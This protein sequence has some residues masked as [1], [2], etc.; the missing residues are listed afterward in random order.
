MTSRKVPRRAVLGVDAAWTVTEPSG[1]A[2]GVETETG[3]RLEAV[4]ASYDDF[5]AR[6]EGVE[7]GCE[8]PRG[9]KPNAAALLA[10][11]QKLGRARV[12]LVAV[13]MPLSWT[14][15]ERRRA[16]DDEVSRRYGARKAA[17]HSPSR[18]RPGRISDD[19][20][21]E[22]DQEGYRLCVR[23]PARG[24]IEVYP[25]AAL[26][27]FLNARERLKYKAAKVRAYWPRLSEAERRL[28][29]RNAWAQ[30][31]AALDA[32]LAGVAAALPPP[33][34]DL[35]A[36]RLKAYEDKLDAVVCAAVAIACLDGKAVAHG[37]EAAAIWV[38]SADCPHPRP[39]PAS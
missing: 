32:R 1:V 17:V 18:E 8:R 15:I 4:E 5:L 25:H 33:E 39:L 31:V 27:E 11:A 3:W 20:R 38:P 29:L 10:A 13:D 26:I 2:L 28:E 14:A 22:L 23:P 19:L 34:G 16:C 21:A 36:W 24:L 9:S 37:D 35:P 12:D 6:A 7:P 30:I